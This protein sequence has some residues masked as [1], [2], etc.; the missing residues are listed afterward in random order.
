MIYVGYVTSQTIAIRRLYDNRRDMISLRR[1]LEESRKTHK[2]VADKAGYLSQKLD[3]CQSISD[4][5]DNHI[6]HTGNP[7][8]RPPQR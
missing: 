1:V 2:V 8:R 4:L 5:V 3:T 7:Q 6:A